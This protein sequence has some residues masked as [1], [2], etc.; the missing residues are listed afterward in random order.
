MRN[1]LFFCILLLGVGLIGEGCHENDKIEVEF[2]SQWGGTGTETGKFREP[3]GLALDSEGNI[4]ISDAGNHRIQT[5]T[6]EGEFIIS[7]GE[8]GVEAGQLQR[9]MHLAV[10][11]DSLIF[12]PEYG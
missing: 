9:P 4:Y 12:V 11:T 1:R 6:A 10:N 5:F 3:I 2:I 8:Q 7:W